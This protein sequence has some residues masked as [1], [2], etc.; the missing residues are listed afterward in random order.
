MS[1]FKETAER[2]P[3]RLPRVT[4]SWND[5]QKELNPE[6][7]AELKSSYNDYRLAICFLNH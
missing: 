3:K 5:T 4:N 1:D 6:L 2:L 7:S